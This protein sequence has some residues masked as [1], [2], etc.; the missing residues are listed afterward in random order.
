MKLNYNIV[1]IGY[2][3]VGKTHVAKCLSY[4]SH[5]PY[6]SLDIA[7]KKRL[8]RNLQSYIKENGWEAFRKEEHE[9]LR[10]M[11]GNTHNTIIDCGGGVVDTPENLPLLRQLGKIVWLYADPE[12]L[13][14]RLTNTKRQRLSL[15]GETK[16]CD[17]EEIKTVLARRNP[18]YRELADVTLDASFLTA[19]EIASLILF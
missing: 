18:I 11:V 4:I 9:L 16:A 5:N 3:G 6:I 10:E 17:I 19:Q 2:R 8:G 13:C 7:L 1:L 14:Q 15:T 12:L